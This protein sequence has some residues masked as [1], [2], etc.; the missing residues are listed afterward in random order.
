MSL[1][2]SVHSVS[3]AELMEVAGMVKGLLVAGGGMEV[4]TLTA[5][6]WPGSGV[7]CPLLPE[8]EPELLSAES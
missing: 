3:R 6:V 8:P 7:E 1:L 5:G 2:L 4:S